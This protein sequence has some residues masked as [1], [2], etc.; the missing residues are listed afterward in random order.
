MPMLVWSVAVPIN[1]EE[2]ATESCL[3]DEYDWA[4]LPAMWPPAP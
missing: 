1:T 4:R 3:S 2:D